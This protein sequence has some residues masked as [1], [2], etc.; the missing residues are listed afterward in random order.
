M[1]SVAHDEQQATPGALAADLRAIL[2]LLKRRLREQGG[3]RDL[4][5]SQVSAL[6]RL[7]REG[8]C[9]GSALARAEGMRQQSMAV[10]VAAL[11]A[12]GFVVGTADKAD[13][14]Q[15]ILD[16]TDAARDWIAAGRAI[17]QD[18]LT[19]VIA[20]EL[21]PDEQQQVARAVALL[22]RVAEA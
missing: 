10:I 21:T 1:M 17:R 11:V 15:T 3:M 12:R 20:R 2:G 14:R 18:W 9:T 7:E 5:P 6:A 22:R 8:P 16:L 19:R 4:T 13:G